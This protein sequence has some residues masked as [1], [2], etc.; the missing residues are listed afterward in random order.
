[1][2]RRLFGK[3]PRYHAGDL[4]VID[5]LRKY[6]ADLRKP[7]DTVHYLYFPTESAVEQAA[8]R[9]RAL[10]LVGKVEP[11]ATGSNWCLRANHDLVVNPDSI[12]AERPALEEICASLG[13]DYDGWE[14]AV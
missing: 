10:G 4:Q 11:S 14:A 3:Q 8:A 1:M 13:G 7:R 9:V 12:T 6:G 5:N 2:F